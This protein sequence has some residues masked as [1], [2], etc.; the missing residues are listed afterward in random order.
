MVR[1]VA[2]PGW[3]F[4]SA[5]NADQARVD[6]VLD[7]LR[8]QGFDLRRYRNLIR[9][10]LAWDTV[11]AD[12]RDHATAVLVFWSAT[13]A[14]SEMVNKE[15]DAAAGW[16]GV[17][18][19][20][21]LDGPEHVPERFS[22]TQLVD[23]QA[24]NG[25]AGDPR[26]ARLVE[27]LR[28]APARAAKPDAGA[29]SSATSSGTASATVS[30]IGER[31]QGQSDRPI[32]DRLSPSSVRALSYAEGLRREAGQ[33]RLH[34][35]HLLFGLYEKDGGPTQVALRRAG[36]DR[37]RL[38]TIIEEAVDV[39][40]RPLAD[41][42]PALSEM[43][44]ISVHVQAALAAATQLAD[45][46]PSPTI[47]TRHLLAG[48]FSVEA[49]TL[50]KALR[51][52]GLTEEA[53]IADPDDAA[54]AAVSLNAAFPGFTGDEPSRA[55]HLNFDPYVR[56]F[57]TLLTAKKVEPPISVG[58]FGDWGTGKSTFMRQMQ[59]EIRVTTAAARR[60]EDEHLAGTRE[61]VPDVCS[62]VRQIVFNAWSYVD[63]NLWAGLVTRIFEGLAEPE[64]DERL[65]EHERERRKEERV[66]L[67]KRLE[68]AEVI[69][70]QATERHEDAEKRRREASDRLD[71]VEAEKGRVQEELVELANTQVHVSDPEDLLE[72]AA[73]TVS[74]I[75][76]REVQGTVE[77]LQN[78][79][80]E[81]RAATA[82]LSIALDAAW[83]DPATR[84]WLFG[85]GLLCS[86]LVAVAIVLIATGT[87][88]G[89]VPLVSAIVPG[90]LAY[91]RGLRTKVAEVRKAAAAT[92]GVLRTAEVRRHEELRRKEVELT[93]RQGAL[94]V[95]IQHFTAEAG[96]RR[97]ELETATAAVGEAEREL[98]EIQTG[99]R[100]YTFI[101][102]RASGAHYEK[103]LG[104]IALI[105][106]DFR[107]LDRL[108]RD[109]RVARANGE[110]P[111]EADLPPIDRIVLY[112]DDLDRCPADRVVQVLEAVHLLLAFPLFVVVVGVD[113]R[114]LVRSLERH[115]SAQLTTNDPARTGG[116]DTPR[117]SDDRRHWAATPHNYLEKIF[118]IP[119]T[120]PRMEPD[121]F[122]RLMTDLL[123]GGTAAAT[124]RG[125][126]V[127]R[128]LD[129]PPNG[130][131]DAGST[132]VT[133][134]G[135]IT[136]V[137]A[138]TPGQTPIV[139]AE[140]TD[141]DV[142]EMNPEG[143]SLTDDE[144]RF[145]KKL[146]PLVATPR[147]A[148]R[149]VNTYRLIRAPL[150]QAPLAAFLGV[151]S[152]AKP[153]QACLALLS[154]IV[155]A[156]NLAQAFFELLLSS[157]GSTDWVSFLRSLGDE[158]DPAASDVEADE[159]RDSLQDAESWKS[160]R[161]RLTEISG[162]EMPGDLRVHQGWA[163]EVA[164]Y[165][166]QTV[167]LVGATGPVGKV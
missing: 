44:T 87:A 140:P 23:L 27:A 5:A 68:A 41:D 29:T 91:V 142:R 2:E 158:G 11:M 57:A 58:L 84:P 151:D 162:P 55:D 129:P 65:E 40:P 9:P 141:Q 7:L 100:L 46:S 37:A 155:G 138:G 79:D 17:L 132:S 31:A 95:E 42:P 72:A 98:K 137:D 35:E 77:E 115:Y 54:T 113:A 49:C 13:A 101:D 45:A 116:L 63:A 33:N 39:L 4:V 123:A 22:D 161:D 104:V 61:K 92:A 48:A 110:E 6:P 69:E 16:G 107:K 18:L 76:G 130:E 73:A 148:K 85:A 12:V 119:F 47:R 28:E 24:W 36:I 66:Q 38:E 64:E 20:A 106:K 80:T 112:I 131:V 14:R 30:H 165:S 25:D 120:I 62:N 118:Q 75:I 152:V 145:I 51:A 150:E 8:S 86:L 117:S 128:V 15:A 82:R 21:V 136:D 10:A 59:A 50:T 166:F 53:L 89:V 83:K 94:H 111:L 127:K 164:R 93:A 56:A 149:L 143:L 156:P 19:G 154:V 52:A 114:W 90:A 102:E 78:L 163:V 122:E 81:L 153:Y 139:E 160:L 26:L 96:Q 70:R 103:Y 125:S 147:A 71:E 144:R 32:F 60:A 105:R 121:G 133:Q 1:A 34:M 88:E 108:L 43:P 146:A 167:R 135:T 126:P 159:R 97:K 124:P 67:F 157:D 3:I 134:D 109:A 99:R 74:A